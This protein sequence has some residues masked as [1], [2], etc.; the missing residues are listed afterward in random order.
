MVD[1]QFIK[2]EIN[3]V[4]G[5][6]G[7]EDIKRDEFLA[8]TQVV[9][10]RD[11]EKVYG[12]WAKAF[13]KAGFKPLRYDSISNEELF[14]EYGKLVKKLGHYPVKTLG[15]KEINDNSKYSASVFKKRFKGGLGE[16]A[17]TYIKWAKETAPKELKIEDSVKISENVKVLINPP[18]T[19]IQLS[20]QEKRFFNGKAAEYLLIS[21]LLFRGYNAQTLPVDEGLDVFAV[22]GNALYLFQVKHT[23]YKNASE[24]GPVHLTISS[25]DRNKGHNVFYILVLSRREP[26]VRSFLIL[27]YTKVDELIR[28]GVMKQEVGAKQICFKVLHKTNEDAYIEKLDEVSNVSRYLNAWD[29]L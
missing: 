22:K 14:I 13:D 12:G 11:I 16:F 25:F 8:N 19:E 10:R 2:D 5:L 4:V 1:E 9:T 28:N 7:R 23:K 15:Q 18:V 29:V 3:R 17:R 21:E 27:P 26:S 6:L 24:S 20:S